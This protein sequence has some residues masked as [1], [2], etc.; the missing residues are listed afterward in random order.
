M[1]QFVFATTFVYR[2]AQ[3]TEFRT[4][5]GLYT[6]TVVF[7]TD[8]VFSRGV[9]EIRFVANLGKPESS[10]GFLGKHKIEIRNSGTR[11]GLLLTS[12]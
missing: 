4:E 6:N 12:A 3:F 8:T 10:S 9:F 7:K 2:K 1:E 11:K 5:V